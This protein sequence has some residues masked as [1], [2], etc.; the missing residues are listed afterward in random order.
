MCT[1]RFR[2]L[3]LAA[4]LLLGLV[5]QPFLHSENLWW[6]AEDAAAT[7]MST[8]G[9]YTPQG[10]D[11]ALVSGGKWLNGKVAEG[12]YAEYSVTVVDGGRYSLLARRFWLHGAFRW[13]FDEQAWAEVQTLK[14]ETLDQVSSSKGPVTW[15]D[16]GYAELTPGPHKLRIELMADSAY[17]YNSVFAFDCFALSNDGFVPQGI[18]RAGGPRKVPPT[19]APTE[20]GRFLPRTM[21]LLESATPEHHTPVDI[22]FYGQSI[23]ANTNIE[24]DLVQ[25]LREKYPNANITSKGL[26][27]GGYQAPALRKTAWQDLYPRNPDLIVFHVYGGEGGELEEIY[28][29]IRANLTAEVLTWTHHVDDYGPGIDKERDKSSEFI[30]ELAGRYGFEV[31]DVRTAWKEYLKETHLDP[32]ALLTDQIHPNPKGSLLLRDIL[33]PH[34][35]VYAPADPAGMA[36]VQTILL[37]Q[38]DPAITYAPGSWEA[39][40]GG[41]VSKGA[42][43]LRIT[44]TGNRLDLTALTAG[45]AG[46]AQIT[47]DGAPPST[48]PDTLAASRST[49]APGAWWPVVSRV[50][51][52]GSAVAEKYTMSFHDVAPDGSKFA[53]NLRGSVTG[54]EGAGVSGE[55]FVSRSGRISIK[56]ADVA[57]TEVKKITKKDLPAAFETDWETYSMSRDTW[58]APRVGKPGNVPRATVI[59]CWSNQLHTVEITPAGDSPVSLKEVMIFTPQGR[60]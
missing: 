32:H 46:T 33:A 40:E 19:A 58:T 6:E 30:K 48:Q 4:P 60:N 49:L 35:Q 11:V 57:L 37:G 20:F 54:D 17:K 38:P 5:T 44:F 27:I 45:A 41:L 55:D 29:A 39:R 28:R 43:P 12:L 16:L 1:P 51:L 42:Q 18:D 3:C 10:A 53:F 25:F 24:R 34:F 31:A 15:V 14:Q 26:A 47:L 56:S 7:S 13:R 23:I 2:S 52:S 36:G 8:E 9:A 59:R 22:V 50:T 21:A